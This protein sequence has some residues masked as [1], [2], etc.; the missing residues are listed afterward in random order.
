LNRRFKAALIS[1][2]PRSRVFAVAMMLNPRCAVT[3]S[4]SSGMLVCFSLRIEINESWI[5]DD[6]RVISS[7]RAHLPSRIAR[8]TGDGTSAFWLGPSARSSA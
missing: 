1:L 8:S 6:V 5:S 7:K 2:T 3:I 4:F